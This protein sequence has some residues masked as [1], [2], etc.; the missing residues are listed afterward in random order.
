MKSQLLPLRFSKQKYNSLFTSCTQQ[1]SKWRAIQEKKKEQD[2]FSQQDKQS[3][4]EKMKGILKNNQDAWAVSYKK[5]QKDNIN[6]FLRNLEGKQKEENEAT[7]Y[8]LEL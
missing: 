2:V 5:A 7:L 6:D 1:I 3:D 8:S 4:E